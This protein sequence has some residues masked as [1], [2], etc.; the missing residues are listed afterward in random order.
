MHKN[1]Q[2]KPKSKSPAHRFKADPEKEFCFTK[3]KHLLGEANN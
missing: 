1:R 3:I 2:N